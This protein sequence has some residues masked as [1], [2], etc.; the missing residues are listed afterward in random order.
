VLFSGPRAEPP[1][2]PWPRAARSAQAK[3]TITHWNSF[4]GA[5]GKVM[6]ELIDQFTKDTGGLKG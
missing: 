4:S 3:S 6:D 2:S 1:R 5:D